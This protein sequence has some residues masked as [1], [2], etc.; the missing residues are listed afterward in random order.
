MLDYIRMLRSR[1]GNEKIL[2]PGA[3]ALIFNRDEH[4]LLEKQS[5]FGSWALPHGCVDLGESALEALIREVREETGLAVI[6]A[7]PFGLYSHPRYSVTYPNGDEVQTFT[8]AFLV[9]KWSGDLCI[10]GEEVSELGFFPM[11]ELPQPIYPIH[12]ETIADYGA[13]EGKFIMK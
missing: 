3:R 9:K 1:I 11:R 8:I 12:I 2:V 4:L 10:D 6:E 5:H 7:E 13:Y